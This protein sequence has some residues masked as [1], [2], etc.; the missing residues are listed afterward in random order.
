[1]LERD[2]HGTGAP[3]PAYRP[4]FGEWMKQEIQAGLAEYLADPA[5]A[6]PI[7]AW[8]DARAEQPRK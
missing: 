1:M 3:L 2:A 6:V 5:K 7:E 4:A 8:I